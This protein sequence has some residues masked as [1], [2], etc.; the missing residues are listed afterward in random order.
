MLWG[1]YLKSI[2]GKEIINN[3]CLNT[4]FDDESYFEV[5][6]LLRFVKEGLNRDAKYY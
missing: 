2:Q 5:D 3:P 6:F 1:V 4:E